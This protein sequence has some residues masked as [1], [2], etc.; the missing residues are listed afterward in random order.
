VK[1]F[2]GKINQGKLF[3]ENSRLPQGDDNLRGSRNIGSFQK[4]LFI[5]DSRRLRVRLMGSVY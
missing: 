3:R 4:L 1:Q 2:V 5:T